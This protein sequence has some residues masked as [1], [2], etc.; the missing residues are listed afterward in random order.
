MTAG[1]VEN[2]GQLRLTDRICQIKTYADLM[3]VQKEGKIGAVMT[4]EEGGV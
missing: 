2:A 3:Q 1:K 4:V